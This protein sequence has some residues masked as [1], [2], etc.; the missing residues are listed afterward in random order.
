MSLIYGTGAGCGPARG[1]DPNSTV[2]AGMSTA[3][4]QAAL[5]AAQAAYVQLQ[6]GAKVV[7]VGYAQGDGSR[8]VTYSQAT[9]AGLTGF[10]EMLQRQLGM[11]GRGRRP[12]IPVFR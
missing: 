2:L 11:G 5:A 8:N 3:Q 6:T 7:S 1:F 9:V 12:M 10:I 4:L